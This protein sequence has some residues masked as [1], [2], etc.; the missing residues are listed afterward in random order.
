MDGWMNGWDGIDG[1]VSGQSVPRHGPGFGSFVMGKQ[2][3]RRAPPFFPIRRRWE[4]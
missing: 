2:K 3:E 1:V 4:C